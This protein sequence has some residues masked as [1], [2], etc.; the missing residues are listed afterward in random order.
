MKNSIKLYVSLVTLITIFASTLVFN[1][2]T[3]AKVREPELNPPYA[4]DTYLK[5][6]YTDGEYTCVTWGGSA[7]HCDWD[8]SGCSGPF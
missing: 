5:Y 3:N 6:C 4:P 7:I 1:N 2:V 8:G